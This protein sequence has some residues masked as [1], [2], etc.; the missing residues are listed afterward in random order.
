MREG[1]E[2]SKSE[3]R[4]STSGSAGRGSANWATYTSL[5]TFAETKPLRCHFSLDFGEA[6]LVSFPNHTGRS[7][8]FSYGTAFLCATKGKIKKI[9]Q[10]GEGVEQTGYSSLGTLQKTTKQ[11]RLWILPFNNFT[12]P[13]NLSSLGLTASTVRGSGSPLSLFPRGH[14][15]VS[16][17]SFPSERKPETHGAPAGQDS[18]PSGGQSWPFVKQSQVIKLG[19]VL[20][21]GFNNDEKRLLIARYPNCACVTEKDRSKRENRTTTSGSA[22]RGSANWATYS[23]LVYCVRQ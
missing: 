11:R 16:Y 22:G 4:T 12:V 8:C 1:K 20:H 14:S 10:G 18:V 23:S 13:G 19:I 21:V 5:V 15:P 3:I 7:C 2:S 9:E 6:S 17:Q